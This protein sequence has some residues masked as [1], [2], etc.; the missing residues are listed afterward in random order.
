[1]IYIFNVGV[2]YNPTTL[3]VWI[4]PFVFTA[5][6]IY[7]IVIKKAVIEL[8]WKYWLLLIVSCAVVA[9]IM[10]LLYYSASVI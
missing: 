10:M 7:F 3:D 8:K 5:F 4:I 1:M 2:L 6:I 9:Y